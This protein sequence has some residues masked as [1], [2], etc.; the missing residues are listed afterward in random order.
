VDR[1]FAFIHYNV[2]VQPQLLGDYRGD[3]DSQPWILAARPRHDTA[4]TARAE[5]T[6][7]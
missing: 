3:G 6:V 5:E 2:T 1:V 4:H 7:N